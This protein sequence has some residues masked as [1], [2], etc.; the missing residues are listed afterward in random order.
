MGYLRRDREPGVLCE[1]TSAALKHFQKCYRLDD[2]GEGDKATLT[3]LQKHRCGVPDIGSD[4]ETSSGPAPFVLRG[5]SYPNHHLTYA[6]AN[7][8]PDL[9]G[10]REQEIVREAFATWAAVTPLRF[11]EVAPNEG[12]DFP[13]S[14]QR[15]NHGDGSSFDGPGNVLAHAFFPPPCG[16]PFAG[17]LHFDEAE[18]WTDA[19]S[20]GSIRLLNVA[21]HEIGHLLGLSHSATQD[22]IMFAF[23]DDDV[24]A[25]RPDDVAGIQALYGPR[26]TG[27][28]PIRG[29]LSSTG[30][31]ELHQI[32][33]D[34]PGE[35]VATLT[36]P[37]GADFDLYLRRG[38]PPNRGQFDARGFTSSSRERVR[39]NVSGGTVFVLADSWRG[40]GDYT[41]EIEIL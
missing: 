10:T 41:I 38:Q 25:L 27:L 19:A 1:C 8:T 33:A 28:A 11:T 36:G 15:R 31:T 22:A 32:T 21:I 24:D 4:P 17:A 37:L 18:F 20:A 3:Q 5:C 6:F 29:H 40:S 14:W 16:G 23:Y 26:A 7:G 2:S 30:Q 35:L 12:P 34:R 13:I 9:G 39:L